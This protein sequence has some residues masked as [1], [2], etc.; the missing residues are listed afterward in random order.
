MSDTMLAGV[1]VEEGVLD[2]R[3]RSVP[4]ISR[5]DEVL[6]EIE[7]CGLCGT[8][9]HV[10]AVPPGVEA[11]PGVT[12]GHEFI[13]RIVETGREVSEF[14][15][16][17][18]VAVDP[19]LKC[20]ICRY[21]R[22]GLV[23]HCEN[24]TTL[25]IHVDGGF[26]R[27]AIAPQRALHPIA[28]DVPLEEAVWTELLSCVLASTD[29]IA[30]QPGQTAAVIGAGPVGVLHGM[31]F[32]AAGARVIISD[33]ATTRLT[34]A[35]RAG[36]D[37]TVDVNHQQLAEVVAQLTDGLGADVVVDA[38]GNQFPT[39]LEVAGR[40]AVVSLFGMN[41]WAQ[42]PVQQSVITRQEITVFGSYVG[43][44]AFPRAIE[45]LEQRI[46]TPSVLISHTLPVEQL[47]DGVS[48]A[49]KGEAMKV[50]VTPT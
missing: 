50:M 33:I 12:L 29:Q 18:R 39:C 45:V 4:E 3:E 6:I 27:Y 48:A 24:W 5:T 1:F 25:G 49:R 19:N 22:R 31:L 10:L 36:I 8:D 46:I 23:N 17:D 47:V 41:E 40:Q 2:V 30:V 9:L 15:V 21:C 35:R 32:Q 42:P 37:T 38:V 11:T 13:G 14:A 34:L 28:A 44:N 7:G 16:G 26:A 20:G 43:Y